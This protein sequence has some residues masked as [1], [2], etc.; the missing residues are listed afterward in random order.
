MDL[1]TYWPILIYF[2]QLAPEF[3][4]FF[5]V[6]TFIY[7]WILGSFGGGLLGGGKWSYCLSLFLPHPNVSQ[8]SIYTNLFPYI[9]YS[10]CMSLSWSQPVHVSQSEHL[11]SLN[12]NLLMSPPEPLHISQSEPLMSVNF[13]PLMSPYTPSCLSIWTSKCLWISIP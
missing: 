13:N 3:K 5:F 4:C 12:F 7:Y 10:L 11:M 9:S 8:S 6:W 2:F 1:K